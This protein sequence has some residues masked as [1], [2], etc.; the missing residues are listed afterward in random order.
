VSNKPKILFTK[1]LTK[2]Q[3]ASTAAMGLDLDILPF[4]SVTYEFDTVELSTCD[5]WVITSGHAA[6]Y[7]STHF[8]DF[9][10]SMLPKVVYAISPKSTRLIENLG[11]NIQ[12]AGHDAESL[13]N[14][15]AADDSIEKVIFFCGNKRRDMLPTILTGAGMEVTEHKVYSTSLVNKAVDVSAYR[16]IA[17]ASPSAVEGFAEL[18]KVSSQDIFV[19]GDTTAEAASQL[20]DAQPIVATQPSIEDLLNTIY[21]H[22]KPK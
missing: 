4:I 21:Y 7:L 5:A 6:N 10:K 22:Y 19:I 20:L 13:A 3:K 16:G 14:H 18:N 12:Y 2:L 9:D 8:D 17:F 15:I 1:T 11:L